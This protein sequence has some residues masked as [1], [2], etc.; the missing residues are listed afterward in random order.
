MEMD[1]DHCHL[2]P[3]LQ[4]DPENTEVS[5]VTLSIGFGLFNETIILL[6]CHITYCIERF[7]KYLF[8]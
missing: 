6:F 3:N 8:F 7:K 4:Q 2:H 1:L 5:N